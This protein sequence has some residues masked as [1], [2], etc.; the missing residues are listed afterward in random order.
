MS[1]WRKRV[2]PEPVTPPPIP[3]PRQTQL[4]PLPEISVGGFDA[5]GRPGI[6][7]REA[8]L[9]P[10]RCVCSKPFPQTIPGC[11]VRCARCGGML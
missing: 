10:A 8:P 1:K 7:R 5:L 6:Q 3:A 4:G 11:G 9:P 2:A